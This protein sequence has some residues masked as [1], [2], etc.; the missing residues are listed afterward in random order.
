MSDDL[1]E[2]S[3]TDIV[4]GA[5]FVLFK[6]GGKV[7]KAGPLTINRADEW[8]SKADAAAALGI[9]VDI[10]AERVNALTTDYAKA[11][12]GEP[13]AA[14]KDLHERV[15]SARTDW[16]SA[17]R[18]YLDAMRECIAEY[19]D[20]LNMDELMDRGLTDGQVISAFSRLRHFNDPLAQQR[21]CIA[22]ALKAQ[23]NALS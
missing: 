16:R 10:V 20:K 15:E 12:R 4:N 18:A 7:Y 13:E 22:A 6:V 14:A 8:L 3:E 17:L 23:K 21:L 11:M 2:R 19:D 1:Y 5:E 9:P